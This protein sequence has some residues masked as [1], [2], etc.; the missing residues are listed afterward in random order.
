MA[1]QEQD[2]LWNGLSAETQE[3]YRENYK[4]YL[5]NSEREIKCNDGGY[6]LTVLRSQ[7]IVKELENMFGAH[8]L[9][10]Q[11]KVTYDTI[12]S[13]LK[14]VG[15]FSVI[16]ANLVYASRKQFEK[17]EAITKLLNV[18]AWLNGDW[19]AD[20]KNTERKWYLSIIDGQIKLDYT[21]SNNYSVVYFRTNELALQAIQILG[22]ETIRLALTTDY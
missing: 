1:T 17:V 5:A 10:P 20:F 6:D 22:E 3:A 16:P 11:M 14:E 4:F 19:K 18:A 8:N 21:I 15:K 7:T 9:K 2:E 13:D 12:L